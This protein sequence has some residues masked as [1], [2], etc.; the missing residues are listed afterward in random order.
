MQKNTY[1]IIPAYNESKN[2]EKVI[3]K[4]KK[5]CKNIIIVDDG[6]SDNTYLTAK[7]TGVIVLGHIVNLGKGAA[8]KTGCD[9][10]I[11]KG[12]EIII[13]LDADGQHDPKEIPKFLE[14]LKDCNIVLG[15]RKLNKKMPLV[16]KLG[17]WFISFI[18]RFLYR[19]NIKDTQ[20][21]YRAFN[22]KTYKKIRWDALDYSMESE[23]IAQIGKNKLKYQQIPIETIYSEKYKGTTIMDGIKIVLD[24]FWWKLTK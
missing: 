7:K 3:K 18:T 24:M 11:K 13:S 14:A 8:L 21:G 15:Y 19:I 5:Y 17:N 9:F 16:L 20:C 12:A 6:S 23:M 1:I 10:A 4:T 22:V 2:I